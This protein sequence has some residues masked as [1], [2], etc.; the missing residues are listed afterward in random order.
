MARDIEAKLARK[1][2]DAN[3]AYSLIEVVETAAG[4]YVVLRRS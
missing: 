4:F 3:D 2:A 1:V